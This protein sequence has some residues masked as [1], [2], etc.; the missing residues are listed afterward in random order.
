MRIIVDVMGGDFGPSEL[1][2]GVYEASQEYNASF[3]VV[4]N[5]A[6]IEQTAADNNYDLRKF[7]IVDTSVVI[8]MEDDPLCVVRA[9]KD[10]SMSTALRLLSEGRGD[11]MVSAGNSGALFTGASLIVRKI[12]G[13]RRAAIASLLPFATPVLLLDS[14]AN[15][16]VDEETLEQFAVMGSAYMKHCFDLPEPRV[17]LLNNGVE[18]CKGTELRL[19]AYQRLKGAENIN[20]IGNVEGNRVAFDVCDVLVTDG[21]CGNILLKSIEGMGKLMINELKSLF[22]ASNV[23]K[24]SALLV[25]RGVS[26]LRHRY[27]SKEYGGA[28]ILGISKPVIKAHGSSDAKA[29]KNAVRQAISVV[30]TGVTYDIAREAVNFEKRRL[31]EQKTRHAEREAQEAKNE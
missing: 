29:M 10:S 27:D 28:P 11:A 12:R 19:A 20:F 2:K 23:S 9:K 16:T 4:G 5:R 8:T 7:E 22:L 31:E 1:F 15:L 25:K 17:G 6:Q 3:I 21:F 26:E 24:L 18:E 30:D 13:V 14:G